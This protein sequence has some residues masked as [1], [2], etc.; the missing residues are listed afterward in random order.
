MLEN[1]ENIEKDKIKEDAIDPSL[2]TN[3]S[4]VTSDES[5][6]VSDNAAET[7]NESSSIDANLNN[8]NDSKSE[9]ANDENSNS[10]S[11]PFIIGKKK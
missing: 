9:S 3:N 5:V 6:N 11:L 7:V 8:V 2:A 10:V 1:K 4:S